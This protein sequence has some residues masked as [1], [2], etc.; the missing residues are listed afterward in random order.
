MGQLEGV[1]GTDLELWANGGSANPCRRY[2]RHSTHVISGA[3][4]TRN[5]RRDRQSCRQLEDE[6]SKCCIVLDLR[7]MDLS[8]DSSTLILF[9]VLFLLAGTVSC[10]RLPVLA[11]LQDGVAGSCVVQ[12]VR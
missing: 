12:L 8:F 6:G 9:L 1:P 5:L 2:H 10:T 3:E 11:S 4:E 7:A